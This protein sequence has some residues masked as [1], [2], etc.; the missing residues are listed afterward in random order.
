MRKY[1]I[2]LGEITRTVQQTFFKYLEKYPMEDWFA[3]ASE[4]EKRMS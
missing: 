2:S 4:R 3:K 1:E